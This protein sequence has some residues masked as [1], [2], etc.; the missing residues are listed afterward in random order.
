MLGSGSRR[1]LTSAI[2]LSL[3]RPH[4]IP[5]TIISNRVP[6]LYCIISAITHPTSWITSL[7]WLHALLIIQNQPRLAELV[8]KLA[9]RNGG[10][11]AATRRRGGNRI[12]R[13]RRNIVGSPYNL[14][15][16]YS[17]VLSSINMDFVLNLWTRRQG[18][19]EVK[20]PRGAGCVCCQH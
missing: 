8:Q 5:W 14:S 15:S 1:W 13:P 3:F 20:Q 9:R 4:V 6:S 19:E 2:C 16:E 10:L 18:P 12:F 11:F 17:A 7:R